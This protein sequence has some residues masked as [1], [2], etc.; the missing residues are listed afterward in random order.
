MGIEMLL[1]IEEILDA[2]SISRSTF[3]RLRATKGRIG[4]DIGLP[5]PTGTD[6]GDFSNLPPFPPPTIML[7][8]SP[9]W[10]VT[11]LN[12]WIAKCPKGK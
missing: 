10:S 4:T 11:A 1:G 6:Y 7:G 2:L 8:R 9:R 12:E 3:E 5:N